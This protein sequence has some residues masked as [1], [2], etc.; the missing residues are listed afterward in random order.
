MITRLYVPVK[1]ISEANMREH[2]AT[3]HRRKKEQKRIV[4]LAFKASIVPI[5]KPPVHVILTRVGVRK[6]DPDNLA[7]SFKHTQDQIAEILGVDDGDDTMVTWE[8]RQR[9][10]LP[11]EYGCEVEVTRAAA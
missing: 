1:L 5:P 6:L 7:G 4:A 10:G 2:W 11:K 3:K 8:Y 9:K